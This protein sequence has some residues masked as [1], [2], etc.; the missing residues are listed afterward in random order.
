MTEQTYTLTYVALLVI[1]RKWRLTSLVAM[2]AFIVAKYIRARVR[3]SPDYCLRLQAHVPCDKNCHY[4]NEMVSTKHHMKICYHIRF[5]LC[6]IF[7]C[8]MKLFRTEVAFSE[9]DD[10]SYAAT[11]LEVTI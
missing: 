1:C 7:S 10:N 9:I 4:Q 11:L 2:D 5:Q 6:G 3:R 8:V